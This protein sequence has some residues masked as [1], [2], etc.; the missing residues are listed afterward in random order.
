MLNRGKFFELNKMVSDFKKEVDGILKKYHAEI[1]ELEHKRD[2][3]QPKY[4]ENLEREINT[5]YKKL[6]N[7]EKQ[8]A[9]NK[10]QPVFDEIEASVKEWTQEA[11]KMD[12][13]QRIELIKSA[14]I[15]VGREEGEMLYRSSKGNYLAE[16]AFFKYASSQSDNGS[17]AFKNIK[18][19]EPTLE[20]FLEDIRRVKSEV[21]TSVKYYCGKGDQQETKLIE[22]NDVVAFVFISKSE[23]DIKPMFDS[24]SKKWADF[25]VKDEEMITE[26]EKEWLKSGIGSSSGYNAKEKANLFMQQYLGSEEIIALSD[27]YGQLISQ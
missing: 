9:V 10:V 24:V 13:I 18:L 20:E 26:S 14:G 4:L 7:I 12:F 2:R 5:R 25:M 22:S 3:F 15:Q 1:A 11:P 8:I 16:R 19:K 6:L 17:N 23:K 27:E 21:E